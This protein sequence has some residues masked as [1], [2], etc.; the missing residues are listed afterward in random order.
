MYVDTS[1]FM[2]AIGTPSPFREACQGILEAAVARRV[3]L[4]TSAE[5]LQELLHRYR[6]LGR[7]GQVRIAFNAV[8]VSVEQLFPVTGADVEEA[9]RLG[10]K[11]PRG[12]AV[13]ARDLVHAAVARRNGVREILTTDRHMNVIPGV[14]VIDP[15]TW[16]PP[17]AG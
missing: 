3:V 17:S 10:E 1:V 8:T 4:V 15:L 13:P 11:L 12:S 14:V 6:S 5:T 16:D 7:E 2:Y 9:R